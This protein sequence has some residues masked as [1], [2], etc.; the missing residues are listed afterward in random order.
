MIDA[1]GP[2]PLSWMRPFRRRGRNQLPAPS[3]LDRTIRLSPAIRGRTQTLDRP[4]WETMH[5]PILYT[6]YLCPDH[7]DDQG[8]MNYHV[9]TCRWHP[10]VASSQGANLDNCFLPC[11]SPRHE[12]CT[13]GDSSYHLVQFQADHSLWSDTWFLLICM[14]RQI[15]MMCLASTQATDPPI[16][17]SLLSRAMMT[18][19]TE[20]CHGIC[21]L[22]LHCP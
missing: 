10:S 18:W 3:S 6:V 13:L 5:T 7:L 14:T 22:R 1:R 20:K 9:C 4:I 8:Y 17:G 19:T 15:P 2:H 16:W 11:I 21:C 12:T